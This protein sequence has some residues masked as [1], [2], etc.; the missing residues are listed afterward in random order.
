ML[1]KDQTLLNYADSVV[2]A[3]KADD[4]KKAVDTLYKMFDHVSDYYGPRVANA[5]E[6]SFVEAIEAEDPDQFFSLI[7]AVIIYAYFAVR[8]EM[9]LPHIIRKKMDYEKA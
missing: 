4:A 5:M 2:K 8:P 1:R 6:S 7:A 3:F 9:L